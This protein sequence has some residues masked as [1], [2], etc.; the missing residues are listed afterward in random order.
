MQSYFLVVLVVCVV[1][2]ANGRVISDNRKKP[3]EAAYG[4]NTMFGAQD[5]TGKNLSVKSCYMKIEEL[6]LHRIRSVF[7]SKNSESEID[8]WSPELGT[9]IWEHSG[10]YEGDIMLYGKNGLLDT[11][12]H[13]PNATVPYYIDE[14]FGKPHKKVTSSTISSKIL[15]NSLFP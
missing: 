5:E 9:N 12:S 2:G 7:N 13:W 3:A 14:S 11:E 10:L 6:T 8:S 4:Y 1:N 15:K